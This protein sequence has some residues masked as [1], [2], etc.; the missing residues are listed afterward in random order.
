MGEW[1]PRSVRQVVLVAKNEA[2]AE[3][4]E[5]VLE[6]PTIDIGLDRVKPEYLEFIRNR[7]KGMVSQKMTWP[8]Y[9]D[10]L[11]KNK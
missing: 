3:S 6:R 5:T 2:R 9:R 8:E 11:A 10:G 1:I 4:E 7:D